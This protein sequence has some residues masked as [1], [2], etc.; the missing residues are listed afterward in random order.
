MKRRALLLIVSGI[1]LAGCRLGPAYERPPVAVP[2]QWQAAPA[3][4]ESI[5]N[6]DWWSVYRDETLQDL[7][8][9]ALTEN[10]DLRL[11]AERIEQ[12]KAQYGFT[13]A[14]VWP[15][16]D[17]RASAGIT[18]ERG[19]D[20]EEVYGA[21]VDLSWE[22]DVFGRLRSA[23]EAAWASMLATEETRRAI[24]LSLVAE[25][26]RA[27]FELRDLDLELLITRETLESRRKA[28]DLVRVLF[29]GGVRSELDFRQAEAEYYRIQVILHGLEQRVAL[30]EN[31]LSILLGRNPGSI[32]RGLRLDQQPVPDAIPAGIPSTLLERRPDVVAAEQQLIAANARIGEAKALLF[33][34]IALTGSYG[35]VSTELGDAFD[36]GARSWN[37]VGA[38]LQPLFNA[39][40]NRRRVEVTE[41]QQRQALIAYEAAVQQAFR[42]VEDALV[43]YTKLTEQTNAQRARVEALREVLR[44]AEL[45]Y[46]G[47]VTAYLEVLDSQRSHFDAQLAAVQSRRD[48][49]VAM[50]RLY[51]A[52]GGGW[53]ESPS[54]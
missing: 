37:L 18:E 21:G 2:A 47:G 46:E 9:L 7:I 8:R 15:K 24:T 54:E 17:A 29:E 20:R 35:G 22:I 40:K 4:D 51:K 11:A 12:A 14:D 43:S 38:L 33:P 10:K 34:V 27:Y 42:E 23:N 48:Q 1:A 3:V 45:R 28:R 30:K 5:A 52:L 41:S 13:R 19:L 31:E 50:A 53:S 6:V 49:L 44:L 39:G 25:V 32:P 16:V 36:S 26:A